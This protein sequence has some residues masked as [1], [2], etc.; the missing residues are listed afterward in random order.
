ML[1]RFTTICWF[2]LLLLSAAY[3]SPLLSSFSFLVVD[4]YLQN[5][6]PTISTTKAIRIRK[7]ITKAPVIDEVEVVVVLPSCDLESY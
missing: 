4:A 3:K 7:K 6:P 2:P 1:P 5:I